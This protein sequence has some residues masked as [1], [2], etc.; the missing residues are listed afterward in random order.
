M[1]SELIKIR[2]EINEALENNDRI[3]LGFAINHL[4]TFINDN[5]S[6][7]KAQELGAQVAHVANGGCI[8]FVGSM[9]GVDVL[10]EKKRIDKIAVASIGQLNIPS[11]EEIVKQFEELK[12]ELKEYSEYISEKPLLPQKIKHRKKRPFHH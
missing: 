11:R 6:L 12:W 2:V 7:L 4:D 5:Q 9:R 3:A 8:A 10:E 1:L